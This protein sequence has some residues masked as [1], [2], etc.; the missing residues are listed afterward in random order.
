MDTAKAVVDKLDKK[1]EKIKSKERKASV[2]L[3]EINDLIESSKGT[4]KIKQEIRKL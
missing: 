2:G 1:I 4:D 3:S